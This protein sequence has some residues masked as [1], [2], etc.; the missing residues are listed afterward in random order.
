MAG[1]LTTQCRSKYAVRMPSPNGDQRMS[2]DNAGVL[3]EALDA[4]EHIHARL[5]DAGFHDIPSNG[6]TVL[7]AVGMAGEEAAGLTRELGISAA[8]TGDTISSL[9]QG[10]YLEFRDVPDEPG[11][12]VTAI[13]RRGNEVLQMATDGLRAVRWATFPFRPDDIVISTPPKSGTTWMQMICALLV[14]RTPDLPAP[15]TELSPWLDWGRGSRAEIHA[16]IG[17][18]RH[19][20]FIKTH[21]PLNDIPISPGVT[22]IVVARHPL[23]TAISYY[24]QRSNIATIHASQSSG[25]PAADAAAEPPRDWLLRWVDVDTLP[26]VRRDSLAGVLWH[27]SDAWARRNQPN[28]ALVHYEDLSADLEGEMRSLAA[29]LQTTVPEPAWPGLVKAA[30]FDQMRASASHITPLKRMKDPAAFFRKGTSGSGRELLAQ[31]ELAHYHARTAE[32]AP[33]DLLAW[34]HRS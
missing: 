28:V 5:L 26:Q 11:T 12:Q 20:R 2:R 19:R 1:Q 22:Y 4:S 8:A 14:F 10:G 23:D 15:L 9:I 6:V 21:M 29:R 7:G 24:H 30:T 33:A 18:Q 27:L 3:R 17:E 31:A 13:T 25:P 32:L 16:R 34:L